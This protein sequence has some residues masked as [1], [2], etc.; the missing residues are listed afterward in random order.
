[1]HLILAGN[2][3]YIALAASLLLGFVIQLWSGYQAGGYLAAGYL[4]LVWHDASQIAAILVMTGVTLAISLALSRWMF[5]FGR[6]R[7]VAALAVGVL[8]SIVFQILRNGF[9]LPALEMRNISF[10]VPGLIANQCLHQGIPLTLV[11]LL[12]S[13]AAIFALLGVIAW[14]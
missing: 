10:I 5:L 4:A 6:R 14:L 13:S 2:E 1:M 3:L 7:F 12:L 9:V 8:V 11:Y